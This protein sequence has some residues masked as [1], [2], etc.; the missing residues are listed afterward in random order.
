MRHFL[1]E[2][3]HLRRGDGRVE[4][5]PHLRLRAEWDLYRK[6]AQ[7]LLKAWQQIEMSEVGPRSVVGNYVRAYQN[8]ADEINDGRH[9]LESLSVWDH[10]PSPAPTADPSSPEAR[11]KR[12]R[13]P[14]PIANVS[15]KRRALLKLHLAAVAYGMHSGS[16]VDDSTAGHRGAGLNGRGNPARV[17]LVITFCLGGWLRDLTQEGV[18]PNP[19]PVDQMHLDVDGPIVNPPGPGD[20][21][22]PAPDGQ[23]ALT[24]PVDFQGLASAHASQV[25][26]M[27]LC[28]IESDQ[29][30]FDKK[31][32]AS[33]TLV[34]QIEKL[35]RTP[36]DQWLLSDGLCNPELPLHINS[37]HVFNHK[38]LG[39]ESLKG[40]HS[41]M[42]VSAP[43]PFD[44]APP[45]FSLRS[46]CQLFRQT[47]SLQGPSA[48]SITIVLVSRSTTPTLQLIPLLDKRFELDMLKS[49][50]R[51]VWVLPD[52][53]LAERDTHSGH[54]YTQAWPS[55]YP[56]MLYSF[57]SARTPGNQKIPAL[58]AWLDSSPLDEDIELPPESRAHHVL[59]NLPSTGAGQEGRNRAMSATRILMILN[60]LDPSESSTQFRFASNLR[61]PLDWL[62]QVQRAAPDSVTIAHYHVPS[63]V[64]SSL[65][66]DGPNLLENGIRWCV[67]GAAP[68]FIINH[69]PNKQK[70]SASKPFKCQADEILE[71]LLSPPAVSRLFSQ[72]MALNRW[73][74][75]AE[76][77]QGVDP[78][79][80]ADTLL[81]LDN[82]LL[83][84]A[85][86]QAVIHPSAGQRV[87]EPP[88]LFL[89]CPPTILVQYAL[90]RV[91]S[92][93][94]IRCHQLVDRPGHA[95]LTLE[96]AAAA[97]ALAGCRIPCT[98]AGNIILTS[99]LADRDRKA[100]EEVGIRGELSLAERK[101][102]LQGL[103][104]TWLSLE[105]VQSLS[106]PE[107]L[108][109]TDTSPK[110]KTRT[111]VT[112]GQHKSVAPLFNRRVSLSSSAEDS[113]P[114]RHLG[115]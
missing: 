83:L 28:Q 90:D 58:V 43:L 48:T 51:G 46:W 61:Y 19:G 72:V 64:V 115:N 29:T 41:V 80:L 26:G 100:S 39:P 96:H 103:P 37:F 78:Q 86:T 68:A 1:D 38:S 67:M 113:Q 71:T 23:P 44:D 95:L 11:H 109:E 20:M 85:S 69:L 34:G 6:Q 36:I 55:P 12:A 32:L 110:G 88:M 106:S 94:S 79:F 7:T 63:H 59:L 25:Y 77:N 31:P 104:N 74:V 56:L 107:S 5:E 30:W 47:L 97:K 112:D 93:T 111:P 99:G 13:S 82:L 35:T 50:K 10:P 15:R 89:I 45:V 102:F 87:V 17:N 18:E 65:E 3:A 75:Y 91:A 49:W 73:D 92:V 22:P 101:A 9:V 76:L 66:E 54:V 40:K 4:M 42:F 8:L 70:G 21:P 2:L 14:S 62:P 16:S 52:I 33:S 24:A 84:S 108:M 114:T 98:G 105:N 60:S 81:N 57:S 27:N 53:H